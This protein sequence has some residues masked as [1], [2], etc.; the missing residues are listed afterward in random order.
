MKLCVLFWTLILASPASWGTHATGNDDSTNPTYNASCNAS[1]LNNCEEED[2]HTHEDSDLL[3]SNSVAAPI[4]DYGHSFLEML[5]I[6]LLIA[7]T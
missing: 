6:G 4:G 7:G 2:D 5:A 3:S 1:F